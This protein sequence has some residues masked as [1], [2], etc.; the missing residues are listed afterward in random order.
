M[1]E[2]DPA[3]LAAYLTAHDV[4][5]EVTS[6]DDLILINLTRSSILIRPITAI[7]ALAM[8][9][10]ISDAG[11]RR[12]MRLV[13]NYATQLEVAPLEPTTNDD[14]Q[15]DA[16]EATVADENDLPH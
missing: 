11:T 2:I 3:R 7:P 8:S 12:A 10:L 9:G 16:P 1:M 13:L 6:R 14:T 15:T 5:A 4:V